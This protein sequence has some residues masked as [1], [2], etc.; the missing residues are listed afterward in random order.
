MDRFNVCLSQRKVI[1]LSRLQAVRF[2]PNLSHTITPQKLLLVASAVSILLLLVRRN[3]WQCAQ[4]K[5]LTSSGSPIHGN[6]HTIQ[7][8]QWHGST[9]YRAGLLMK[10]YRLRQYG[11]LQG[12]FSVLFLVG[13]QAWLM[14]AGQSPCDHENKIL[15]WSIISH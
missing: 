9:V 15:T 14:E 7:P 6:S 12:P 3:G 4:V 8:V 1:N 5:T 2:R 11:N 13:M 10:L